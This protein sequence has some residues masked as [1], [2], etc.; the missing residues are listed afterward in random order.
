MT[1]TQGALQERNNRSKQE[2]HS[3]QFPRFLRLHCSSQLMASQG[4]SKFAF[5]SFLN[6]PG[7]HQ[8]LLPH[9]G[10]RVQSPDKICSLLT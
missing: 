9:Q 4:I 7:S 1:S 8:P 10:H 6:V 2:A 3:V 5:S